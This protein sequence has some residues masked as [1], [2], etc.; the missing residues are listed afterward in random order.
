MLPAQILERVEYLKPWFHTIDLGNGMVIER[1]PEYGPERDYPEVL[2]RK[3]QRVL[4]QN[5]DGLRVLDVGCNGGFFSVEMKRAGAGYVL[6][7]E[8]FPQYFEQA[9]LVREIVGMEID[10]RCMNVYDLTDDLGPFDIS[11][12]LGVLYHLK[13]PIGALEKLA[14]VTRGVLVVESAVLPEAPQ[15]PGEPGPW[16]V[17]PRD[18][19]GPIHQLAFTENVESVDEGLKNWFV[20][21]VGCLEA[22]VKTAGFANITSTSVSGERAILTAYR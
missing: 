21:S 14:R 15:A 22:F 18:Y 3:V 2:W 1:D 4:P 6:G 5:L 20:P 13:N 8:A 9:K 11:L 17:K 12:F 19:G 10:L 16:Q 7:I